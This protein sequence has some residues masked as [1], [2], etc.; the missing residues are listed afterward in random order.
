VSAGED[1]DRAHKL[2]ARACGRM[3]YMLVK[4]R[5]P[6]AELEQTLKGLEEAGDIIRSLLTPT[7]PSG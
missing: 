3:V 7:G 6:K 1:L 5:I 4:Y 2:A